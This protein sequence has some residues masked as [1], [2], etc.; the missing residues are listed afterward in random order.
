MTTWISSTHPCQMLTEVGSMAIM[1][2]WSQEDG[3]EP[4]KL[5]LR[6]SGYYYVSSHNNIISPRHLLHV[7]F[8]DIFSDCKLNTQLEYAFHFFYIK[9]EEE[10][11]LWMSIS[12]WLFYYFVLS[13]SLHKKVFVGGGGS[14]YMLIIR[15][16]HSMFISNSI[17]DF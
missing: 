17:F 8:L 12:L 11:S 6:W 1:T 10:K 14:S 13:E 9:V 15:L 16:I 3:R 7:H 5:E 4:K 2:A